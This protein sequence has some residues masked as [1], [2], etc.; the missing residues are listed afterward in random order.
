MEDRLRVLF[1]K[2]RLGRSSSPTKFQQGESSMRPSEKEGQP[3]NMRQPRMRVDFPRWE[4]DPTGWISRVKCYFHYYRIS[5]DSMV[6][7]A[8][9][10]LE[11]DAIQWYNWLE[12]THGALTWI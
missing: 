12:Y 9:N 11:G 3:S 4:G 5:E 8:I 1:V 7:I 6:D 2:F 10:H